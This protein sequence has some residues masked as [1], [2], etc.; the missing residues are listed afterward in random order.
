MERI[1]SRQRVVRNGEDITIGGFEG[2]LVIKQRVAAIIARFGIIVIHA[3][4]RTQ[5]VV[6]EHIVDES[7]GVGTA[8][9]FI[10]LTGSEEH[11]ADKGGLGV[12]LLQR[13]Y[14]QSL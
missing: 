11:A 3:V 2:L 4:G 13:I 10:E 6:I 14:V 9:F 7:S 12:E 5:R 8:D 1:G